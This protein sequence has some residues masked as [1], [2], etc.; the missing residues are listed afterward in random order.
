[1]ETIDSTISIWTKP[2]R[3]AIDLTQEELADCVGCSTITIQKI[4]LGER[5]PS[6][7]MALRLV[8][9][10]R[11]P[12][13]EQEDFVRL[14][15][16]NGGEFT[17]P[18]L[19]ES[20]ANG[21]EQLPA[22]PPS[23]ARASAV[24]SGY[25]PPNNLPMSL[26]P[27][28]GREEA[29]ANA[30]EYLLMPRGARLLTLTGAPGIGK[31]RLSMQVAAELLPHFDEGVF[32]V[33]L[34]PISD[35]SQ[36]AL[37]IAATLGLAESG[38][39][40]MEHNLNNY[41]TGKN[42][43]LVLDNFEH[44][45][46][47]APL[48]LELLSSCPGLKVLVTSREALHVPGEQQF[49]VSPLDLPDPARLPN[50]QALPHYPA[51]ALFLERAQAVDPAF[52]LSEENALDITTICTRLDGLPLAIELAAAR[53]R[54]LSTAEMS[55]RLDRQLSLLTGSA[56]AKHYIQF[57]HLPARQKTMR[58]A[59]DWSYHLLEAGEQQMLCRLGVFVAGWTLEAAEAVCGP[60]A[61]DGVES[62]LGKSLIYAIPHSPGHRFTMLEAIREYALEGLE[63]SGE[64]EEARRCH[65]LYFLDLV[66]RAE[67]HLTGE[68]QAEWFRRLEQEHSNLVAAMSWSIAQGKEDIALRFGGALTL[69]WF[70]RYPREGR[71]WVEG[72]LT[73]G[74]KESPV[75]LTRARALYSA[76]M[77]LVKTGE[78]PQA[79][80]LLEASLRLYRALD[81]RWGIATTLRWIANLMFE[82]NL[83]GDRQ[84]G[85][86]LFEESLERFQA[87]GDKRGIARVLGSLAEHA[88]GD[89]D[90]PRAIDAFEKSLVL[91]R[92]VKD[93]HGIADNAT[94]LAYVFY[95][96]GEYERARVLLDESLLLYREVASAY[97]VAWVLVGWAGIERVQG[98]PRKAA[99]LMGAANALAAAGGTLFD[100]NDQRDR[101]EIEAAI[102]ADLSELEW[103]QA[104]DRGGIMSMD[105]AIAYSV[106]YGSA[107]PDLPSM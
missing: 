20:P 97:S 2:R 27:L 3:R 62:L 102:R 85:G 13:E 17:M 19:A 88:R 99:T 74:A 6:K 69:F 61:L 9:C 15:R 87:I 75:T 58:A 77:V 104:Q 64:A 81:D 86:K 84:L 92:E 76:A 51:I 40:L 72:A 34:A 70:N 105:E 8:E 21:A 33:Q 46:D 41:L 100:P 79:R 54:L 53:V 47:A 23:S 103:G 1:M 66:E 52:R 18:D 106:G 89:E 22:L 29:V 25:S 42:I 50:L 35:P 73:E 44:V 49:P 48:V 43:L 95:H 16:G 98:D 59:I 36:V 30:N 94:N 39:G 78:Y 96:C 24:P 12:L 32:F 31:T 28:L 101:E 107:E 65:A 55:A 37:A 7:Q 71:W 90:Y 14:A 67:P 93:S 91:L 4:E 26:T 38:S 45:L 11:I 80:A 83:P 57:Q 56:R 82:M 5:R 60:D 10:L 63:A 68:E